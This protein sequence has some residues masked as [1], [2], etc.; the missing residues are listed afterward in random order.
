MYLIAQ[1]LADNI[2]EQYKTLGH[3][4]TD[5]FNFDFLLKG[6]RLV[7]PPH[8]V[9]IFPEKYISCYILLTDQIL[10]TGCL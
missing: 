3:C 2:N 8:F 4:S 10:L 5:M 7:S 9:M 1:N 6:L